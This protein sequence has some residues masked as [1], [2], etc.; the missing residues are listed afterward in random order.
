MVDF[1]IVARHVHPIASQRGMTTKI[2]AAMS[3]EQLLAPDDIDSSSDVWSLAVVAYHALTGAM[4]F[5]GE[6]YPDLFMAIDRADFRPPSAF[7][8]DLS[9]AMD[10][11][12][13]HAFRPA[14]DDRFATATELAT[15]FQRA[16]HGTGDSVFFLGAPRVSRTTGPV[17]V[18]EVAPRLASD[19]PTALD[20][21]EQTYDESAELRRRARRRAWGRWAVPVGAVIGTFAVAVAILRPGMEPLTSA[22][23]AQPE[24]VSGAAFDAARAVP[25]DETEVTIVTVP[26]PES[27][28]AAAP[29]TAPSS[30]DGAPRTPVT[31]PRARFQAAPQED[32]VDKIDDTPKPKRR[33]ADRSDNPYEDDKPPPPPSVA[34]APVPVPVTDPG[35]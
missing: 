13:A 31:P 6:S 2:A 4:P 21:D 34:P 24:S 32:K 14:K 7:R 29:E 30:R 3:P 1:E 18:S 10:E 25:A 28:P 12:F 33:G 11:L 9:P 16:A 27:L 20:F 17:P 8:R 26:T 23:Y 5:A 19:A 22:S 15:A 35:F